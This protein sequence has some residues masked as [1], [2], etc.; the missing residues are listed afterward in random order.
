MNIMAKKLRDN[1]TYVVHKIKETKEVTDLYSQYD[2]FGK[3]DLIYEVFDEIKYVTYKDGVFYDQKTGEKVIVSTFIYSSKHEE[4][5]EPEEAIYEYS[6]KEREFYSYPIEFI[7]YNPVNIPIDIHLDKSKVYKVMSKL[8]GKNKGK[9]KLSF[10]KEEA[11][12][13]IDEFIYKPNNLEMP[14]QKEKKNKSDEIQKLLD[15]IN[16]ICSKLPNDIKSRIQKKVDKLLSD[17]EKDK[18][19][20]KP[21]LGN[22][23]SSLNANGFKSIE[24]LKPA[25]LANLSSIILGLSSANE[26]LT[27]L[28]K[29][30]KYK[31]LINEDVNLLE[32]N[33]ENEVN[34][35]LYFSKF[36]GQDEQEKIKS[37]LQKYIDGAIENANLEL[38]N[39]LEGKLSL[40]KSIN[41]ELDFKV[42]VSSLYDETYAKYKKIKPY[43]E[44]LDA[45][46]K[47]DTE[48]KEGNSLSDI[49]SSVSYI[50]SSL[51]ND[52]NAKFIMDFNDIIKKYSDIIKN[53]IGNPDLLEN[54]DPKKIEGNIRK[55]LQDLI[56]KIN[57]YNFNFSFEKQKANKEN[58][59]RQIKD[60][61]NLIYSNE[62]IEISEDKKLDA[63]TSYIIEI[64]NKALSSSFIDEDNLFILRGMLSEKLSKAENLI[65]NEK[66]DSISK[67][68]SALHKILYE[69]AEV[70]LD[71]YSFVRETERFQRISK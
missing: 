69:L 64:I 16:K 19:S 56:V 18:K 65:E 49:V 33:I 44:M 32:E 6:K 21:K 29:L 26:V 40:P 3:Y 1:S 46:N 30:N 61:K 47:F 60:S 31:A 28:N 54:T 7:N 13:Q 37:A 42:K 66:I 63:I 34:N 4:A 57:E 22:N 14:K 50:I 12:R 10:D 36:L 15:E 51:S 27:F 67:Y 8:N 20:L 5:Q 52:K 2:T 59:L 53:I 55:R 39:S 45:L 25:L 68:N 62:I 70:D 41:Y 9:I 58:L 48:Y 71:V 35:L 11:L 38:S 24:S 23:S 17:Y 43:K